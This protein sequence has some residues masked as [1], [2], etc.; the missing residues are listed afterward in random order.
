MKTIL[1]RAS[2]R[3]HANHGWLDTRH[4]FSF[5][6]YFNPDRMNFGLLRVVNDDIV[7][8]GEGFG[9]HP[10]ENMEIVSIPLHGALAHKDSMGHTEVIEVGEVQVMSAGTGITHSEYNASEE[11][12]V[13][14]F[15]IW[16]F[17]EENGLKP[18]YDQKA[19]DFMHN[20]NKLVQIVGPKKDE[21]NHGLWVHQDVWFNIG[22]FDKGESTVYKVKKEG[23]GVFAMV[24]EGEFA[25]E[26]QK[27]HRRDA[28]GLWDTGKIEIKAESEDARILLI[29]VPMEH[30]K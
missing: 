26:G 21:S 20:K 5:A 22:T 30:R 16:V 24:V 1:Y 8:P 4:T 19:F 25:V 13:G 7:A 14:F 11:K 3:G 10:H 9:T 15:Q 29:D 6:N 17:P 28:L 2:T 12:P 23:N 27:L 18:R